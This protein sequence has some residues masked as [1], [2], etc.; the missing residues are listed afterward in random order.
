MTVL[1]RFEKLGLTFEPA[2]PGYV[3]VRPESAV[4][5][6]LAAEIKRLKAI[7]LRE[8]AERE[9]RRL[10]PCYACRGTDFWIS[11]QGAIICARCHPPADERL[12]R[13]RVQAA[14]E[15]APEPRS[16]C[17]EVRNSELVRLGAYVE[18][19]GEVL[20]EGL[21]FTV[22]SQRQP[23]REDVWAIVRHRDGRTEIRYL[24]EREAKLQDAGR[25]K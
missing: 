17:V 10:R 14:P 9:R 6:E 8:L 1:E 18:P 20:A 2:E 11:H 25:E 21:C 5:P 7:I 23:G 3:I 4:T 22:P 15:P 19:P 13:E 12:V 24:G 16:W